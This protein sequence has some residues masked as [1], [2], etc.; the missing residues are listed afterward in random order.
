[1]FPL[2]RLDVLAALAVSAATLFVTYSDPEETSKPVTT[3][4]TA[5]SPTLTP[6]LWF[7]SN[8]E[9]AAKFYCSIFPNSKVTKSTPQLVEFT[10]NGRSFMA[11]NGGPHYR[12]TAAYSTFVACEDQAEVD[13]YWD[14]LLAGGGKP[15]QCGWLEDR[16][17]VSWQIIPKRLMELLEHRDAATRKRATDAMMKMIKID[18]AELE[19]AVATKR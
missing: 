5:T 10:L 6:F 15:T 2:L 3:R 18:V 8:A 17:G 7:E 4:P 1:M 9:E 19:R 13:R 11:L 16:Y 14:A 12:L